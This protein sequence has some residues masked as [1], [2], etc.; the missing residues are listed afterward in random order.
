MEH[1][2]IPDLSGLTE[3]ELAAKINELSKKLAIA[4]RTGN[5]YLCVQ[6]RMALESY[7]AKYQEKLQASYKKASN[8]GPNFDD[9]IQIR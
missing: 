4:A 5:G 2:L 9:K 8:E 6:I 3:E 1:P 7:Q